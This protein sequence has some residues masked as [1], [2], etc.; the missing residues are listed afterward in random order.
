MVNAEIMRCQWVANYRPSD[1][2]TAYHDVEWGHPLRHDDQLLFELLTLEI[3]QA[4]LSW[5]ISLNKRPGLKQAFKNFDIAA[6]SEMTAADELALRDNPNIIRNRLKIAA[7][8]NNAKA[9]LTVQKD[10]GSFSDYM[11]HF[12]DHAVVDHH[13]TD[14]ALIPA[15]DSLSQQVAK[16]MKQ[17]GF[18]FAGPV[19]IYSYLQGM[20]VINDHEEMCSFK[21]HN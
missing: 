16:D 17:R 2:M 5:E 15:Q 3:F 18:K 20:G 11:W 13:V 14:M 21:Y 7:T 10:F 4:G 9:I 19:T 1:T 6:V 12:T 8:I